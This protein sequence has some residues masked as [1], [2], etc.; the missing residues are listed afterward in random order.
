[1]DK[2]FRYQT[3]DF[4]NFRNFM[5]HKLWVR[6]KVRVLWYHWYFL[7]INDHVRPFEVTL[8]S[9]YVCL[10]YAW[11]SIELIFVWNTLAMLNYWIKRVKRLD[12]ENDRLRV[13]VLD[14]SFEIYFIDFSA[15]EHAYAPKICLLA[16]FLTLNKMVKF[17]KNL[18]R[19]DWLVTVLLSTITLCIQQL[20]MLRAHLVWTK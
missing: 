10:D 17:F 2:I 1:M 13:V 14:S 7:G 9:Y 3:P 15:L 20:Q 12:S 19:C 6:N 16:L 18:V 11:K 5:T 4:R 8:R